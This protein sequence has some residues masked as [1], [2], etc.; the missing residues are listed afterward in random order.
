M[1]VFFSAES[2]CSEKPGSV[3]S[4]HNDQE[5]TGIK[6]VPLVYCMVSSGS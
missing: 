1:H 3:C 6:E 5:G 4:F 2:H